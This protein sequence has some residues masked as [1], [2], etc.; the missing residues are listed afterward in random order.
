MDPDD[1]AEAAL[2][3][4][5]LNTRKSGE[6]LVCAGYV[7]NSSAT[8]MMLTVGDGVYGFTL[9]WS[10][11]EFVLSHED[12]KIPET[13]ERAGRFYSGN[14]GNVDKWA[15]EMRAY[16]EHLQ[17]CLLYTSPSPRDQRGSR[18]PSSA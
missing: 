1:D 14:Q 7:M 17:G 16:V 9:D 4:C 18:M 8:V 3:K 15:P 5:V 6:E 10:T 11:G 2:E 12:V 13:T